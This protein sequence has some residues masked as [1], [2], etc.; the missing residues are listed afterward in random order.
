MTMATAGNALRLTL[1]ERRGTHKSEFLECGDVAKWVA[2]TGCGLY[3][4]LS[5]FYLFWVISA[6][7]ERANALLRAR[8]RPRFARLVLR[9]T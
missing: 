2:R 7:A 1:A 5:S 6:Y 8:W 4:R 3:A 9:I